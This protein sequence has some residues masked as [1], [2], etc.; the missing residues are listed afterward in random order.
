M[1]KILILCKQV[2]TAKKLTNQVV[3]RLENLRLI[4]IATDLGEA[5]MLIES[6][7]PDLIIST[8]VNLLQLITDKFISYFPRDS[9][10]I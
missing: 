5:R 1:L 8:D 2:D 3:R 10:Y 4:G 6:V 9:Y 7:E